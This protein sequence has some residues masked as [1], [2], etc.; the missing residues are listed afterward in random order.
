MSAVS[1][2]AHLARRPRKQSGIPRRKFLSHHSSLTERKR[3]GEKERENSR[4]KISCD[5]M[6]AKKFDSIVVN[7]RNCGTKERG[8]SCKSRL[9][10][11]GTR[12]GYGSLIT[13]DYET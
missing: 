7:A 12:Y 3:E 1:R 5:K 13:R 6:I 8:L 11:G 9:Y 10:L 4:V 2:G